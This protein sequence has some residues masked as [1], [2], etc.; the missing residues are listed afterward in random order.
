MS[1][2]L[3][4]SYC[5]QTLHIPW[6]TIFFLTTVFFLAHHD[7]HFSARK[8]VFASAS[9]IA[10]AT[11]EGSL[12]RQ[13]ALLSL[14]MFGIIG[15]MKKGRIRLK[16][17]G[18]L[19]WLILFFMFWGL[20]SISWGVDIELTFR[21]C[22]VFAMLWFGALAV[23]KHF[24]PK[25]ILFL[26][27]LSCGAFLIIGV[28][29]EVILGKFHPFHSDYRF[30]G[31]LAPNHQGWNCV[32]LLIAGILLYK[33]VIRG[34]VFFILTGLIALTFLV[35]TKSRSAFVS[36]I[37]AL[38]VYLALVSSIK[39]KLAL[40]LGVS[41]TFCLLLLL[42]GEAFFPAIRHGILLGRGDPAVVRTLTGRVPLWRE[43]LQYIGERPFLGYGFNSFWTPKHV[44]DISEKVNWSVPGAHCGYLEMVLSLGIVGG[45]AYGCVLF[46]GLKRSIQLHWRRVSHELAGFF[47]VLLF[48]SLA[49]LMEQIA[50]E[51]CIPG[52][53]A[54]AILAKLGLLDTHKLCVGT[55]SGKVHRS[56]G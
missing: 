9:E 38:F 48:Y 8:V 5:A 40:I 46:L 56:K 35:L 29:A 1:R 49:M 31:T 30:C 53:V 15:L 32:L 23:A 39:R 6:V 33:D 47:T 22:V 16:I 17:N 52:F 11:V 2:E 14:G 3:T 36:V 44:I 26:A 13:V 28:C 27:F 51:V 18:F 12:K 42:V 4:K 45:V 19:G 54:L 25:N 41:L 43:C 10:E 37:L 55:S 20:L 34:R 7:L 24:S 21:K 50:T